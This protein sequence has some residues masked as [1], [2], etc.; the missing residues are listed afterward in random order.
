MILITFLPMGIVVFL[1]L[2]LHDVNT[3]KKPMVTITVDMTQELRQG[4][5][6]ISFGSEGLQDWLAG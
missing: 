1:D 2:K 3:N 4:S 6:E 5:I